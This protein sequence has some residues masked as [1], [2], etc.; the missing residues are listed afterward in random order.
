MGFLSGLLTPPI[1]Y[2]CSGKNVSLREPRM[3]DFVAWKTLRQ[4]SRSFLEPWEPK[5]ND[6]DF[7][8]S[9]FRRRLQHYARLAEDDMAYPFFIFDV[10]GATLLGGITLS[11]V[12][13]GVSQMATLGYWIGAAHANQGHMSG[14]LEAVVG[15]ARG[16]LELH[17]LEAACLPANTASIRLLQ[18][19]G[20]EREGFAKKY[21]MIAGQWED[22]ILW[23]R[24]TVA[25]G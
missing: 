17:R 19:A 1:S 7:L 14:A 20:F 10:S 3:E 23:G 9:A 16:E 6:D 21:L 4:N 5:W 12:R 2:G 25:V 11:N 13:R 22:H 24:N 8:T 15:F 18:S